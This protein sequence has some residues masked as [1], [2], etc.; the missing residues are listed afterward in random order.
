MIDEIK[1]NIAYSEILVYTEDG[2]ILY[3]N[4]NVANYDIHPWHTAKFNDIPQ[5]EKECGVTFPYRLKSSDSNELRMYLSRFYSQNFEGL[6]DNSFGNFSVFSLDEIYNSDMLFIYP[7]ILYNNDLFHKYDTIDLDGRVVECVNKGRAKVVFIQA[8]EGFYGQ[9]DNDFLWVSNLSTKYNFEKDGIVVV[10]S[11]FLT[12]DLY[13]ELIKNGLIKDNFTIIPYSYFQFSLWF[14]QGGFIL[15]DK[16]KNEMRENFEWFEKNNK[17]NRKTHHFLSF[18]RITKPHRLA[19]FAELMTNEKLK[20]KSIKSL[21][22]CHNKYP[23]EFFNILSSSLGDDYKHSKTRL[24]KFYSTYDS[25]KHYVYDESDL[26]NNKAASLNKLAHSNTFLN[27]VTESLIDDRSIFYSEKIYKPMYCAQPFVLIGNPFSL[28]K[29]KELGFKTFEKWWDESYDLETT[30]TKRF[31]K[32]IDTLEYI[33]SWDMDKCYQV[34]QEMEETLKHNFELMISNNEV[35]KLF[36]LL[37]IKE[38]ET[39]LI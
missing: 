3:P 28:K 27:I 38:D 25:S 20:D 35:I 37:E 2:R 4:S 5:M 14:H 33:A 32:I 29:L 6:M 15:S 26:E 22:A 12:T 23:L 16:S 17:L 19:I 24:L 30:F 31:E 34:T 9:N 39:K 7:I 36:K 11:N 18:N 1:I 8:T 13:P 21:G 10:T